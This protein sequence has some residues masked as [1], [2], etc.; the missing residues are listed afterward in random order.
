MTIAIAFNHPGINL[1]ERSLEEL[2]ELYHKPLD[3]G[4][5]TDGARV[6]YPDNVRASVCHNTRGAPGRRALRHDRSLPASEIAGARFSGVD[7]SLPR[8]EKIDVMERKMENV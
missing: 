1:C 2:V 7:R 4:V 6:D 5:H 8:P 3:L